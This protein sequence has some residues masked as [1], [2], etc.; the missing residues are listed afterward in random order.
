MNYIN[1]GPGKYRSSRTKRPYKKRTAFAIKIKQK[2]KMLIKKIV[3]N[4][5]V[6][7]FWFNV[8][9]TVYRL[10]RFVSKLF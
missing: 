6:L 5:L 4:R 9:S 1:D 8:A 7:M 2:C 10:V 3:R